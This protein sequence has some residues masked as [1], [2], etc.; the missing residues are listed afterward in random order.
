[1]CWG[2]ALLVT[3]WGLPGPDAPADSDFAY[4]DVV[5][6]IINSA[7][8]GVGLCGALSL[9]CNWVRMLLVGSQLFVVSILHVDVYQ[10]GL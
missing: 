3:L 10:L 1:M 7:Q 6:A 5:T 9:L 4:K 2:T 8:V